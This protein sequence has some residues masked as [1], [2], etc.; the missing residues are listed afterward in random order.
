MKFGREL[1]I[2][3]RVPEPSDVMHPGAAPL[4]RA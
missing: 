2:L 3:A 4:E 1:V